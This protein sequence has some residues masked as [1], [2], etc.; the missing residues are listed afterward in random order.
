MNTTVNLE[1]GRVYKETNKLRFVLRDDKKI[2]QQWWDATPTVNLGWTGEMPVGGPVGEWRDI[3]L[4][5]E[6]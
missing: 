2:L 4:E 5:E 1:A 3:P 6:T